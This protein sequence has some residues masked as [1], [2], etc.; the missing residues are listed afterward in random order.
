[1][2]IFM[3]NIVLKHDHILIKTD[4]DDAFGI[5]R[6]YVVKHNFCYLFTTRVF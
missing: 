4:E 2:P 3:E 5:T 1:M 6:G